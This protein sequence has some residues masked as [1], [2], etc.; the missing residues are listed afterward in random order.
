MTHMPAAHPDHHLP[1]APS[2][3]GARLSA[4]SK[5]NSAAARTRLPIVALTAAA[6]GLLLAACSG[7]GELE[8]TDARSRMSPML[9]GVGAVYLDI[10]N[11][12]DADDQLLGGAV[13][14][15]VAGAVEV[16]ET[17]DAEGMDA[18]DMDRGDMDAEEMD[19]GDMDA[20]EMDPGDMDP[21]DMDAGEMDA[22]EMDAGEMDPGDMEQTPEG[23][24]MMGM[25]EI[26]ALIIPAGETV[27][28]VPGGFHLMLIDLAEDLVPGATF[29]LTLTFADAGEV[30]VN[31]EVREDV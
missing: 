18:T 16:H 13:D 15:S 5:G 12:T 9:T 27:E 30:T 8:V 26:D 7:A 3:A 1:P 25:R 19:P 6:L 24:A 20:G 14:A 10:T 21:G 22:G 29:D 23:F 28:L 2:R 17:F 31:V 11:G 4:P